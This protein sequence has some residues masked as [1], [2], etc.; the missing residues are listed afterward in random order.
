MERDGSWRAAF[1]D[2]FGPA[3]FAVPEP[4]PIER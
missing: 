3:G 1:V 2:N 4:P